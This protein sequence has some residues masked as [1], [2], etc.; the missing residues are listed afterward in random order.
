MIDGVTPADLQRL[1][2]ELFV[3]ERL[4]LAIVGPFR[5]DKRFAA[6]LPS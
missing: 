1:A 3:T 2:G 4:N 6:L 5:S